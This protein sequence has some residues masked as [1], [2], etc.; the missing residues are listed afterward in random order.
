MVSY[1]YPI[2]SPIVYNLQYQESRLRYLSSAY[3]FFHVF[4]CSYFKRVVMDW[5]RFEYEHEYD[6]VYGIGC[7]IAQGVVNIFSFSGGCYTMHST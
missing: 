4:L 1:S 3:V 6:T 7:G 5:S 2:Y